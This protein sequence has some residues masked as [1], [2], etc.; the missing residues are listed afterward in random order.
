MQIIIRK[1]LRAEHQN[2]T[3]I[4]L[5][6]KWYWKYPEEYMELWKNELT[7]S[8]A[9]IRDNLVYVAEVDGKVIGVLSIHEQEKDRWMDQVFVQ[10]GFWLDNLFILPEFIGQG[11][12]KLLFQF[13]QDLCRDRGIS[14]L[15]LFSDP[16]ARGFYSKAGAKYIKETPSTIKGRTLPLFEL[17][18]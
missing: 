2:L 13:A 18:I 5:T 17:E 12:G 11:V 4:C 10:R 1:A 6:S 16:N 8:A 9:Y 3:N 14:S 7:I 15:Y